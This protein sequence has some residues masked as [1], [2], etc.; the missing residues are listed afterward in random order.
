MLYLP[1]MIDFSSS[2]YKILGDR[3]RK[4]RTSLGLNQED[5]AEAIGLN[6]TSISNI[7]V[8]RHQVPLTVL[9]KIAEILK[10]DV[11]LMLPTF[12][13]VIQHA[14]KQASEYDIIIK[15]KQFTDKTITDIN[16]IVK[17]L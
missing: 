3:I 9:Y 7:E 12:N 16:N 13:E 2:L 8:G 1:S 11:H 6:R 5:L 14:E 4:R 10:I 15:N 17:N